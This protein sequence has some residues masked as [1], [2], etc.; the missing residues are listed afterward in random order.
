M[1]FAYLRIFNQGDEMK[2]I[3]K[4][5]LV[6]CM[7]AGFSTGANASLIGDTITGTG[8]GLFSTANTSSAIIGSGIE[9]SGMNGLV[10]FDFNANSLT[11]S[12]IDKNAIW[13]SLGSFVF[14]N[15]DDTITSFVISPSN[16][17]NG[18][19]GFD[20][21]DLSFGQHSITLNVRGVNPQNINSTLIFD[22]GTTPVG[23]PAQ[24]TVP[25]PTTVALLGLGLFGVAASRRKSARSKNV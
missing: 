21:S 17:N 3:K 20:Q 7:A 13:G 5:V 2:I 14:T 25:E 24:G 12:V 11:L 15:F 18:I 23:V 1:F 6:A 9:F 16:G 19:H 22:I 4:A 8:T 10:K